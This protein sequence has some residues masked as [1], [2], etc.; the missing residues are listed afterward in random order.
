M[1]RVNYQCRISAGKPCV[2]DKPKLETD[3]SRGLY[4]DLD[5]TTGLKSDVASD[6]MVQNLTKLLADFK[7]LHSVYADIMMLCFSCPGHRGER[8]CSHLKALLKDI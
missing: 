1:C 5:S 4:E 8:R 2:T 3:S 7:S 6:S